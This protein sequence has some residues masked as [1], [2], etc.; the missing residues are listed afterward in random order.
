MYILGYFLYPAYLSWLSHSIGICTIAIKN[1]KNMHA[2][3]T[4]E[5]VNIFHFND[6]VFKKLRKN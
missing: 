4:N 2:V 6:K 1:M 3:S 5:I